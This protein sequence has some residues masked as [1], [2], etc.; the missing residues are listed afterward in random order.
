VCL[1]VPLRRRGEV[2]ELGG[3]G[4]ALVSSSCVG[5]C[6]GRGMTKMH[7]MMKGRTTNRQEMKG[8]YRMD[9]G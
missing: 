8:R 6:K 7:R 9:L 3:W 2:V 1:G 5:A 4:V